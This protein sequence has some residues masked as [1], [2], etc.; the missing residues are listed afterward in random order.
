MT[1]EDLDRRLS[2]ISTIWTVLNQAHDGPADA[3]TAARQL[4]IQRYGK[5]INRYLTAALRDSD[6]AD[7]VAQEFAL[8]FVKGD[9]RGASPERGRFRNYL[10][11][12]L[13]HLVSKYRG[14]QRKLPQTLGADNPALEA[15]AAPVDV[16]LEFATCWRD[17]LLTRTWEALNQAQSSYYTVLHFRAAHPDMPSAEMAGKL[18]EQMGKVMTAESVRQTLSRARERFADLLLD[19]GARSVEPLTPERVE[20]ELLE[21]GLMEYCRP[22]WERYQRSSSSG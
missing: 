20:D 7:E 9:F 21:L 16:D 11:T 17:E 6:A 1:Q 5:A 19:E 22:A 3:A 4:V 15:L 10:K 2:R 8:N 14:R 13:F 12:V 18:S